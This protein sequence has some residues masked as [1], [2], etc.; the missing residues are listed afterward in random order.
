LQNL[1]NKMQTT[2]HLLMIEPINFGFNSETFVNNLFQKKEEGNFQQQALLEFTN[3][4]VL[5]KSKGISVTVIKDTPDPFTPDSIFPNNWISFHEKNTIILYPMFAKNRRAERN[6]DIL[7]TI[8]NKFNI[9]TEYDLSA[10]ENEHIFLE[11]TGSMVLD[12]VNKIAYCCLSPRTNELALA[13]FCRLMNYKVVTFCAKDSGNVDIYHTNVMMCVAD[14]FAVICLECITNDTQ[15]INVINT[16]KN[17]GKEI[18][19]ISLQ[20]VNCFAGN[21]LQVKNKDGKLFLVMSL[22][23]YQS[24]TSNQINQLQK[25]NEIIFSSLNTIEK[26]GGGSARCMMAEIF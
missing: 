18:I 7:H 8:K 17:S 22:Q 11:G 24:L 9:S 1:I 2:D 25:C 15:K 19:E 16:L 26:L 20:Q 23:A 10:Y 6:P 5:L 14:K 4:V 21:M 3:F 12:R 13:E